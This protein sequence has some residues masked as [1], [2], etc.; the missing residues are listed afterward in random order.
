[1]SGF[2]KLTICFAAVLFAMSASVFP[3][4]AE[5][6]ENDTP[7]TAVVSAFPPELAVLREELTEATTIPVNGVAFHLGMLDGRNVVLFLSGIGP[8][9]AVMT[10]QLALD[11]F[12]IEQVVFS[13]IA[14]GVDPAFGIGDVVIVERWG[15]YLEVVMARPSADGWEKPPFFEYPFTNFG[16]MFPRAVSVQRAGADEPETR[17]WFPVD[18]SLLAAARSVLSD[19]TLNRCTARGECLDR[20]PQIHIG[21]AGVSGSAF[22]DNAEFRRYVFETFK[23]RV[24]DM[25]SAAIAHVAYAN[26]VPFIAVRSL[27]DLAGGEPDENGI[28]IFLDLAANNAAAVV[29]AFLRAI[30]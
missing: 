15:Q 4:S 8:V 9:N 20:F 13:G 28:S 24:L 18:A 30:P 11:H 1:M 23:A 7:R 26:N 2:E 6:V 22:V 16:M 3:A 12:D 21:G 14:G 29:R 27:S 17:F 10:V 19:V 5:R 25:E